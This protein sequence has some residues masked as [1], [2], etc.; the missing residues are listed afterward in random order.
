MEEQEGHTEDKL[1]KMLIFF[2]IHDV[3][4]IPKTP[5]VQKQTRTENKEEPE[6]PPR[7]EGWATEE[8][9]LQLV[10]AC[11]GFMCYD[12][13]GQRSRRVPPASTHDLWWK[14]RVEKQMEPLGID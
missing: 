11:K 10:P 9:G 6:F 1:L 2:S 4:S 12:A 14:W 5:K 7:Q 3:V 13:E 8:A